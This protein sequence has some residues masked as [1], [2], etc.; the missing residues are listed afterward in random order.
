MKTQAMV[1]TGTGSEIGKVMGIKVADPEAH[2]GAIIFGDLDTAEE[3]YL[4]PPL[5]DE[6]SVSAYIK[7]AFKRIETIVRQRR[8]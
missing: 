2:Y 3:Y 8:H 4:T 5:S 6:L 1:I 7:M